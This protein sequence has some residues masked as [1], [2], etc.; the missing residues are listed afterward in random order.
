MRKI[1]ISDITMKQAEGAALSF[2]EKI[3][4]DSG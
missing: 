2:R 1:H 3:E 4:L